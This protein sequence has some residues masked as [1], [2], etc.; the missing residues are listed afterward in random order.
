MTTNEKENQLKFDFKLASI[1]TIFSITMISSYDY[2]TYIAGCL[3]SQY[4]LFIFVATYFIS[5]GLILAIA[6]DL[7]NKILSRKCSD[8]KTILFLITIFS[9]GMV[10]FIIS[11]LNNAPSKLSYVYGFKD[12]IGRKI[13][14]PAIRAWAQTVEIPKDKTRI[15]IALND[16]PDFIKKLKPDDDFV[17]VQLEYPS[18]SRTPLRVVS[19]KWDFVGGLYLDVKPEGGEPPFSRA[20]E[21]AEISPGVYV[22][23]GVK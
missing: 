13:D 7:S 4:V 10:S 22:W 9:C 19:F 17:V 5:G 15:V 14:V 18:E 21:I 16:A 11:T 12:R 8:W 20:Y 23:R 3:G 1:V 6:I 2:L